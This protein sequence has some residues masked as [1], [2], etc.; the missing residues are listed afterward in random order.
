MFLGY[1]GRSF[2]TGYVLYIDHRTD[3]FHA[4]KKS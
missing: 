4:K 2:V 1:V 3:V